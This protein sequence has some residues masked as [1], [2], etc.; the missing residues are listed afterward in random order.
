MEE[1]KI[2]D[3]IP[4]IV[5]P[6]GVLEL[7]C[8]SVKIHKMEKETEATIEYFSKDFTRRMRFKEDKEKQDLLDELKKKVKRI[9]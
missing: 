7:K 5:L 8:K 6:D 2:V 9:D 3:G 4:C 1:I